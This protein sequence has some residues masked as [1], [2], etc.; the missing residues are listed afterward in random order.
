MRILVTGRDGQLAR[1]LVLR[2]GGLP[3]LEVRAVGRP[4]L[5]LERP[6]TIGPAIAAA[7]PDVVINA[8]AYTAVDQAEAEPERAL[9]INGEAAGEVAAAARARGARVIQVSTDFVFDG[10]ATHPYPEDHPTAPLNVYGRSKLEGEAAVRSANPDHVVVRTSWVYS[11]FGRNFVKTMLRVAAG[12]SDARVVADQKG[13]PTSAL[14]L[15][16]GI[17]RI[18]SSWSDGSSTGL[19]RTY[20]LSGAG[21]ASWFDLASRIFE[22]RRARGLPTAGLEPVPTE[23]WP[24]PAARPAYSALDN[25]AFRDDFG[26]SLPAWPESVDAVV[27]KLLDEDDKA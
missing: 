13:N 27:A 5:D 26:R 19:G 25:S 10:R 21:I 11:P 22:A 9:R 2:G 16:D 12:E 23:A 24:T 18:L 4:E 7:R 1:S 14:D 15:A 20:H 6:G 17:L 8:A 3:G